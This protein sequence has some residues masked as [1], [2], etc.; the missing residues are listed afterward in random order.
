MKPACSDT[1]IG[2]SAGIA[3]ERMFGSVSTSEGC[4]HP[5]QR[6]VA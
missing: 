2:I 3:Y 5:S 1:A 6:L 4:H